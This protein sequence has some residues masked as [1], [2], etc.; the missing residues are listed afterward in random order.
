MIDATL[1]NFDDAYSTVRATM[2]ENK[3]RIADL[4]DEILKQ[5]NVINNLSAALKSAV[6]DTSNYETLVQSYNNYAV[7]LEDEIARLKRRLKYYED[8]PVKG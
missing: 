2:L 7:E 3:Q 4:K 5:D 8:Y 6:E 1:M